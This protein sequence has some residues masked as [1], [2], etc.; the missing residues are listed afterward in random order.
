MKSL[1][2]P[3]I[4]EDIGQR[5]RR[6]S[7]DSTRQ[8][9]KMTVD[10]MVCHLADSY[11]MAVGDHKVAD[12]STLWTRHG[13]KWIVLYAPL[14]WPKD[15]RTFPELDQEV[16][17]TKPEA[18]TADLDRL[19]HALEA[20]LSAVNDGRCVDNPFMGTLSS[21]ELLRWGYLHADHHLRQ[22]GV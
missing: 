6:L 10:Q 4:R 3:G 22:F 13:L 21:R 1:Q 9:G 14:P 15:I 12:V 19:E 17:G 8:W 2:D 7:A 20:F 18:F 5:L 16:G 11:R